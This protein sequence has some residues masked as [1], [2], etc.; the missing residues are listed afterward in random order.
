MKLLVLFVLVLLMSSCCIRHKAYVG[1]RN[2]RHFD[3]YAAPS[4]IYRN[5][6]F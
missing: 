2:H 4:K 1:H 3:K 5:R 6:H